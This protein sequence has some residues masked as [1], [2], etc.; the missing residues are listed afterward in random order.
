MYRFTRRANVCLSV[1]F[2]EKRVFLQSQS[3]TA[4]IRLTPLSQL[5]LFS[6]ALFTAA[7]LAFASAAYVLDLA[8]AGRSGTAAVQSD[9]YADRLASLKAERDQRAAEA[10]SAQ[11]RFRLAMNRIGDQQTEIFRAVEEKRELA[12]A[13]DVLRDRLA[14]AAIQR[15]LA[16]D[17]A[18][19][20]R[21]EVAG[22]AETLTEKGESDLA[23][24]LEA[25]TAALSDA[26]RVRDSALAE[27]EALAGAVAEMEV[28]I[29]TMT[30]RNEEM[31]AEL[32]Y[33]VRTSFEPL[34]GLFEATELDLDSL[35]AEVR[36]DYEGVGGD[37]PSVSMSTR[38]YAPDAIA[39]RF[40]NLLV[41]LDRMNMVRI[42]ADRVPFAQ[43]VAASHRFTSGFGMRRHPLSGRHKMH[44]GVD[45]AA[46]KGT[47]IYATADGV[48]VSAGR[49]GG[50]G[51]TIRIRHG[52]GFETVYAHNNKIHVTVG[53]EVSRGEHIGDMGATG[54]VTGVHLHYEVH[55]HG[56]PVNPMIFVEAARNVF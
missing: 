35:L 31:L 49:E 52:L 8:D 38:S 1:A 2:P 30:R 51:R 5:G 48:V 28:R 39:S 53:Q 18:E 56:K 46:P 14:D 37:G 43:P 29:A 20:L 32:E 27:R 3:G 54:R 26:V 42:A 15:D 24:T 36:R 12:A 13:L 22:V 19:S 16:R 40:D 6:G 47:P 33:A 45:F 34:E 11:S 41:D 23:L 21:S 25:V 44:E 17:E 9:D 10:H 55:Q 4:Y 7:W 50:Y